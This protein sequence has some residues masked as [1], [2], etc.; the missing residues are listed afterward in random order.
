MA[1]NTVN[2]DGAIW[3]VV[4]ILIIVVVMAALLFFGGVFNQQKEVDIKI[5]SPSANSAPTS[6]L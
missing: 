5:E 6:L 2:S 3:A 4:A 1:D